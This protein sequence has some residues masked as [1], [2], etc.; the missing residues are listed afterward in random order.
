M[1]GTVHRT[2]WLVAFA[3]ASIVAAEAEARVPLKNICRVNRQERN[4]LH[5][6]GLVDGLKGS[7]ST[8]NNAGAIA[9]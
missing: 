5:G 9:G 1:T 3:A 8:A 6:L 4:K 2:L 7:G